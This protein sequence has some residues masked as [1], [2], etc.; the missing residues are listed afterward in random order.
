[1]VLYAG[2]PDYWSGLIGTYGLRGF[3]IYIN[4]ET[5]YPYTLAPSPILVTPGLG[6][7]IAFSR[8]FYEQFNE[9]PYAYS[10]CRVNGQ[11]KLMGPPLNDRSLFEQVIATDYSYS[12]SMCILFC[13][14]LETTRACGCNNYVIP[15]PV[16]GYD[17]CIMPSQKKCA[18]EFF[19]FTFSKDDFINENCLQKCPLECTQSQLTTSF[20]YYK[21]PTPDQAYAWSD[22]YPEMNAKFV[23]ETDFWYAPWLEHNLVR[24]SFYYET[25]SYTQFEEKAAM[26][27]DNLI[28]V[29]GG[30]LS[31]LLGM[32]LL[33]FVEL[34]EL[35]VEL[36]VLLSKIGR[37]TRIHKD[38]KDET[39]TIEIK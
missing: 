6:T 33:S 7:R 21:Y 14:Q 20:S 12:R 19:Y 25:L 1:M 36:A 26:S 2:L 32:S 17:F 3:Y 8:S 15:N 29:L 16:E 38:A 31:L 37:K 28:G 5:E 24:V 30:H 13:A 39:E 18:D 10:E 23:N 22:S 27:L 35:T 34:I 4:N 11:N 9:W